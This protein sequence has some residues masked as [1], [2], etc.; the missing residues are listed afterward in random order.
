MAF[1]TK[2]RG[3]GGTNGLP[4]PLPFPLRPRS[5]SPCVLTLCPILLAPPHSHPS[6]SVVVVH[7]VVYALFVGGD[8][9]DVGRVN[10]DV[11]DAGRVSGDVAYVGRRWQ[12]ATWRGDLDGDV[13]CLGG[14]VACCLPTSLDEG[15]GT[16]SGRRSVMSVPSRGPCGHLRRAA[17][18]AAAGGCG[19]VVVTSRGVMGQCLATGGCQTLQLLVINV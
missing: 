4:L 18:T 9:A 15:R 1:E 12:R 8:V 19:L 10:G 13:A 16:R 3:G 7:D 14:D 2:K 17:V 11:A 5:P 6:I